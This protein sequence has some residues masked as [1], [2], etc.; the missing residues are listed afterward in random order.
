MNLHGQETSAHFRDCIPSEPSTSQCCPLVRSSGQIHCLSRVWLV[1]PQV[2]E[3]VCH[4]PHEL[5][6]P[7]TWKNIKCFFNSVN[8]IYRVEITNPDTG[9]LYNDNLSIPDSSVVVGSTVVG[10]S[11]IFFILPC[12]L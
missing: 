9:Y 10:P 6:T 3:H 12:V 7:S 4:S 11:V 5:Q 2:T 1:P 8:I